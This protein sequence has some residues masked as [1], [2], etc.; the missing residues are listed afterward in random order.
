MRAARFTGI[1]TFMRLPNVVGMDG[2][3]AAFLGIPFDTAVTYRIGG[4]F[5]PAAIREASRLLRPYNVE[6]DVEI[7]EHVSAV[8]AGD[9]AVIPGNVQATYEVIATGLSPILSAG[10][11]PLVAVAGPI[12]VAVVDEQ[13][14]LDALAADRELLQQHGADRQIPIAV[15]VDVDLAAGRQRQPAPLLGAVRPQGCADVIGQEPCGGR[16]RPRVAESPGCGQLS[17]HG[18]ARRPRPD[19]RSRRLAVADRPRRGG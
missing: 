2:V 16:Q 15:R 19:D 13:A 17:R 9:L 12:A 5:A 10:V 4:R 1:G 14:R 7:F 6:Q 18:W 8:D 3:D 11:V